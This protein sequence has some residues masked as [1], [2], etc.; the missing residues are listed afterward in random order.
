[1]QL[2]NCRKLTEIPTTPRYNATLFPGSLFFQP[3]PPLSLSLSLSRSRGA[4]RSETL[5]AK[6]SLVVV[7]CELKIEVR[8][9]SQEVSLS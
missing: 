5:G 9:E 2:R 7:I 4:R 1:M 6:L 3:P 8:R